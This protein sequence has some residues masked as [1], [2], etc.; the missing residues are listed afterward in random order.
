MRQP[1]LLPCAAADIEQAYLWY[2]ARSEG[3][4]DEFLSLAQAAID[5][6]GGNPGAAPIVHHDMRR[7]LLRR[8]PHGLF[9]RVIDDQVVVIA[10]FY[11]HRGPRGESP[12]R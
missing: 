8:F 11:A 1:V 2:E 12:R 4:G 6:L 5:N 9:Y 3:L 10:C 7:L